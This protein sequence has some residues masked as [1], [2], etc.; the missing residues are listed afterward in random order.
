[1]VPD[2]AKI[3]DLCCGVGTSTRELYSNFPK[4][5]S[6]IGVDT[7]AEMVS[8]AQFMVEHIA[9][10]KQIFRTKLEQQSWLRPKNLAAAAKKTQK[11]LQFKQTNAEQTD[12]PPK[13]FD[14]VTIMYGFHEIPLEGRDKIL[15]ES[16]RLLQ[17]GALLAVVDITADYEPRYVLPFI[18]HLLD[19]WD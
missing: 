4:A 8:M 3:V 18:L 10:A 15:A 11:R 6:I 1:M 17:K 5:Q 9:S 7:S 19:L 16:Q 2:Q 12:L 14:L 13:S